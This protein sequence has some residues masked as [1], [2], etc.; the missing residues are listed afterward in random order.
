MG[1]MDGELND[2]SL[3]GADCNIEVDA[4]GMTDKAI[5][6]RASVVQT[7]SRIQLNTENKIPHITVAVN[8]KN[9]GK[10]KMSKDI[11]IW[12]PFSMTLNGKILTTG[13]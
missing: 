12:G 11:K 9:G 5:A 7:D 4:I 3:L 1:K 6:V 13:A 10:P 2:L 8:T